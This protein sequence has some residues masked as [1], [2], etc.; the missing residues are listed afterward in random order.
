MRLLV[1][2]IAVVF[3]IGLA[4]LTVIDI[5]RHGVTGIGLVSILVLVVFGVGVLGA[6]GQPPR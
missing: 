2:G 1:F 6:L 5:S 4:V 3:I